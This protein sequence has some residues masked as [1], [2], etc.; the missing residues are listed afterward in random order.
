MSFYYQSYR[1]CFV[2][3]QGA[4]DDLQFA[5]KIVERGILA[6]CGISLCRLLEAGEPDGAIA[7]FEFWFV[8]HVLEKASHHIY[9]V[10]ECPATP[11]A[12]NQAVVTSVETDAKHRANSFTGSSDVFLPKVCRVAFLDGTVELDSTLKC[13]ALKPDGIT[14]LS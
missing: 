5:E 10:F 4:D 2:V 12:Q 9:G 11:G 14:L 3:H 6:L 13:N 7:V 1:N 8:R